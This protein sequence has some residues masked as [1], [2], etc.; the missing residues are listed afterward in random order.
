[1]PG[2]AENEKG[3]SANRAAFCQSAAAIDLLRLERLNVVAVALTEES[4]D[5]EQHVGLLG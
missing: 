5:F 4:E 3:R 2:G 1:V